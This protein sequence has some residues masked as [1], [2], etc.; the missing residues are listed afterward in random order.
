[1]PGCVLPSGWNKLSRLPGEDVSEI[2]SCLGRF[3]PNDFNTLVFSLCLWQLNDEAT[4]DREL[5]ILRQHRRTD[6]GEG[7]PEGFLTIPGALSVRLLHS[8]NVLASPNFATNGYHPNATGNI[9]M[10][11]FSL[12]AHLEPHHDECGKSV[13]E[14]MQASASTTWFPKTLCTES[15]QELHVKPCLMKSRETPTG[16][17]GLAKAYHHLQART[18]RAGLTARATPYS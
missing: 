6:E 4:C 18:R 17:P 12:C 3:S 5:W 13:G 2:L 1:M 9:G 11:G 16:D 8:R 10:M 14:N 7:L 15:E